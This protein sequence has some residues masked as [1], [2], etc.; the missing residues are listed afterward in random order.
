M[1]MKQKSHS[2]PNLKLKNYN[3][4]MQDTKWS[5]LVLGIECIMVH[6]SLQWQMINWDSNKVTIILKEL[7]IKSFP[8][9]LLWVNHEM[10]NGLVQDTGKCHEGE[11]K[12][13]LAFSISLPLPPE[14]T[15]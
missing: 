1:K 9:N 4:T 5:D 15:H 10:E 11:E 13:K 8:N 2:S 3:T 7:S 14:H 12:K 6:W